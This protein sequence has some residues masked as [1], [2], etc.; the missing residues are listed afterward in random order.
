MPVGRSL[1]RGDRCVYD[2]GKRFVGV[3]RTA[4]FVEFAWRLEQGCRL[5]DNITSELKTPLVELLLSIADDKFVMGARN[6]DWTG[7]APILEE[8]IAFS[9][10]AQDDIAHAAALY[11]FVGQLTG[12]GP[13]HVAYGRS[14]EAY[15]NA[16]LVELYDEFDWAVA[17]A[18]QFYCDHFEEIRFTRL[19]RSSCT[20]LA[21]IA[22]RIRIEQRL[23]T[24]HADAWVVRLCK[25]TEES[26]E[27]MQAAL[28]KLAPQA[29]MLFEPTDGVAKLEAA[30]LFPKLDFDSFERWTATVSHV[31]DKAGVELEL[32]RPDPDQRGG[33]RGVHSAE[34]APLLSEITAVYR[35]EPDAVW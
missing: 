6:S 32:K 30:D 1:A 3:G 7:L 14:P 18:R 29:C 35:V 5:M 2:A 22:D 25:G 11:E 26:R 23:H 28:A 4:W 9:A 17:I 27:R 34:F 13:D 19:R 12:E 33:R 15:R 21:Q 24:G 16:Q 20:D 8:D 31:L 10:L